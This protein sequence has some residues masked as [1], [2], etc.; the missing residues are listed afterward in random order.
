MGLNRTPP[1]FF[2]APFGITGL[3]RTWQALTDTA[4]APRAV[5]VVLYLIAA[6]LWTVLMVGYLARAITTRGRLSA[7][8]QDPV[9]NPF[10]SL[11]AIVAMQLG[12]GLHPHAPQTAT[13][14]VD[15]ALAAV[16]GLGCWLTGQWMTGRLDQD[17]F[18]PG[19]LLPTGAGGL[20]ASTDA[21]TVGQPGLGMVCFGI[22]LVCSLMIS[23]LLLQRLSFRPPLP[24]PLIPTLAILVA[25]GPVAGLAWFALTPTPDTLAYI[26]AGYA[27]L[28]T[29]AQIPLLRFYL[30]IPFSPTFWSFTFSAAAVATLSIRW[31]ASQG[32]SA[33]HALSWLI[34]LLVSAFIG[35]I[36]VRSIIS[37]SRGQYFPPA[38][39]ATPTRD[40]RRPGSR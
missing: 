1:S 36:A 25:P 5:S 35:A 18:H 3:A 11:I 29:L 37:L 32:P 30:R 27:I 7:D 38:S 13:I 23:T 31:L 24:A 14:I 4:N 17:K 12:V 39:T 9:L 16:I 15:I 26:L 34:T 6:V 10:V 28:M 22:G 20:L 40:G 33:Q 21:T 8:L 19:Y 2:A